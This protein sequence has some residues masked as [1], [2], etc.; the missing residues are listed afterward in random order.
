MTVSLYHLEAAFAALEA[1]LLDSGGEWTPETEAAFAALGEM[2]ADRMDAYACVIRNAEAE[3]E[4]FGRERDAFAEKAS[5][6]ANRAKRLKARL[7]DY[8]QAR[9]LKEL[10][11]HL[12]RAAVTPNGGKAPVEV[13]LPPEQLPPELA[14]TVVQPDLEL[15]RT[16]ADHAGGEVRLSDGRLVARLLPRGSHLRIR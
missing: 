15:I 6:A 16:A 14:R 4:V 11:G 5:A 3:A 7:L 8:L 1:E 13:L 9:D 12:W 10:R 2:E